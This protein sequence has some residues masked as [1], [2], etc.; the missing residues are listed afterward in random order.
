MSIFDFYLF[1]KCYLAR[2]CTQKSFLA[3]V[4]W[5]KHLY[6]WKE[7]QGFSSS[8]LFSMNY[9]SYR[10]PSMEDGAGNGRWGETNRL[11][12]WDTWANGRPSR[13]FYL[14]KMIPLS[15]LLTNWQEPNHD[16]FPGEEQSRHTWGTQVSSRGGS[17]VWDLELAQIRTFR[18]AVLLSKGLGNKMISWQELTH[19][20]ICWIYCARM[21]IPQSLCVLIS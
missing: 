11:E 18:C 6:F 13:Q 3:K 1:M 8:S 19:I 5:A 20:S 2:N 7:A 14:N 21:D 12:N 9:Y 17:S 10:N 15:P 16:S 4:S